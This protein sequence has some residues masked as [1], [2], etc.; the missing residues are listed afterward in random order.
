MAFMF[1]NLDVYQKAVTF[2]DAIA[3]LTEG[4]PRG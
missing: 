1:E 2:A 3:A 4:F